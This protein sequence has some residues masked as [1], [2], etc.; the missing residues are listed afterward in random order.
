MRIP[1]RLFGALLLAFAAAKLFAAEAPTD[2]PFERGLDKLRLELMAARTGLCALSV[3]AHPDDEDGATISWL[4]RFAGVEVHMCLATRGEGGQNESGPELGEELA[5][6]RTQ[7]TEA[8][9]RILGAKVWYL[10]LP[11]FGFCKSAEETY[12]VWPHDDA[13]GRLVRIIRI[14]KPDIIFTNH[15][16][17]GHDHGHHIATAQIVWEAFDAAADEKRYPEQLDKEGLKPWKAS[18]LY[19]RIW[20]EKEKDK[21][22]VRF[23]VSQR[24]PSSGYSPAEIAAWALERHVTQGMKRDVKPGEKVERT[25]ELAKAATS[26]F[27]KDTPN[28]K[29]FLSGFSEDSGFYVKAENGIIDFR[30]YTNQ[31]DSELA[32][33]GLMGLHDAKKSI[34]STPVNEFELKSHLYRSLIHAQEIIQLGLGTL[35]TVQTT[36]SITVHDEEV[37]ITVRF[38]NTGVVPVKLDSWSLVSEPGWELGSLEL[39]KEAVKPGGVY[40]ATTKIKATDKAIPN[41]PPEKYLDLRFNSRPPVQIVATIKAADEQ[42]AREFSC[43]LP[44]ANVPIHLAPP[45]EVRFAHDPYLVFDDPDRE[46]KE[47]ITCRAKLLVT[48]HRREPWTLFVK[49][50][51]NPRFMAQQAGKTAGAKLAF[52]HEGEVLS[53]EISFT[54]TSGELEKGDLAVTAL[55]FKQGDAFS[56]PVTTRFRRV[57]VKLPSPLNVGIVRTYDTATWDALKLMAGQ[58]SGMSLLELTPEDLQENDLAPL[59]TIVLDLRATQ[60]RPDVLRNRER[61]RKFMEDGGN[62]VCLY[63]KDFDWNE[64]D[65]AARGR[66]F[67][68]GQGGGGAVAPFP[69]TLSFNRVTHEEAAV[70]LLQ[71]AHPLLSRPCKIWEADFAGWV[72]ERGVYFPSKW[73]EKYTPLLSSSDPGEPAL[74][75]GLLVTDLGS[76]NK[77][78]FIYTSYVWYRQL[79]AGVPG[80]YR[81]LANL[82]A[83]PRVKNEK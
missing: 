22:T 16:P 80:A 38:A 42:V 36:N 52:K 57:P 43:M 55:L 29:D 67:F 78:S 20:D 21:I 19:R 54:V 44:K 50:Q 70:K 40:E 48:N 75:G 18:K 37:T 3:A 65:E 74:D 81:M 46:G 79:R 56:V 82:I 83:Y 51:E 5:W 28:E 9:A 11:D 27:Y 30:K 23:D 10:N 63:H 66:G 32:A 26:P 41:F 31:A 39:P 76:G 72:Q 49:P 69:I 45:Y 14:V 35:I 58:I 68:R 25:F 17:E 61:L 13:V 33:Y 47:A 15:N 6:K 77:G 4:R 1:K 62:V 64:P 12:Q 59:H 2:P 24:D 71:P 73:D 53:A 8:A 60:Y 7:E 34:A